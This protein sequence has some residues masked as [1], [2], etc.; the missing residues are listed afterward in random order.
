M[1]RL[2]STAHE[3]A[4]ILRGLKDRINDLEEER[5]PE[6]RVGV[7]RNVDDTALAS[8]SLTVTDSAITV[9]QWDV[10]DWGLSNW[11]DEV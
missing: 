4:Q 3:A 11:G 2:N 5:E 8:D 9:M 6:G 1:N 7:V 10:D